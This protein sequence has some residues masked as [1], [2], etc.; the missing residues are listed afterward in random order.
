MNVV[1]A[2]SHILGERSGKEIESARAESN[3][4]NLRGLTGVVGEVA[5]WPAASLPAET[6]AKE[7]SVPM[8]AADH[9]S[10]E[11]EATSSETM[12]DVADKPNPPGHERRAPLQCLRHRDHVGGKVSAP[13]L[14]ASSLSF[15]S[16]SFLSFLSSLSLP[17]LLHK[18]LRPPPAQTAPTTANKTTVKSNT[19]TSGLKM[20]V[21]FSTS[22]ERSTQK[23]ALRAVQ[24]SYPRCHPILF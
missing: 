8:S 2:N 3:G 16:L 20:R 11:T 4:K 15:L 1:R 21:S 17:L 7:V 9:F 19:L 13:P 23:E 10:A 5:S 18:Q 6:T 12:G 14:D 22:L 24:F